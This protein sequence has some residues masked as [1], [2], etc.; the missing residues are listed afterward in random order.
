M[1]GH[2]SSRGPLEEFFPLSTETGTISSRR[3]SV[4]SCKENL[5][6]ICR[7]AL[8]QRE[9]VGLL[10]AGSPLSAVVGHRHR[11]GRWENPG[12]GSVGSGVSC[13]R[14]PNGTED[15]IVDNV[16]VCYPSSF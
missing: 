3:D 5:T 15:S 14:A 2:L 12:G 9:W 11:A 4:D 1:V 13:E 16:V 6:R 10:G 7:V 8:F